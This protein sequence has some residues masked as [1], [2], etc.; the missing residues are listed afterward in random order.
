M[1]RIVHVRHFR[2][3]GLAVRAGAVGGPDV[4]AG[5]DVEG[6]EA[7]ADAELTTGNTGH[8]HVLD[9][10]RGNGDRGAILVILRLDL[11]RRAL[12]VTRLPQFLARLGIERDQ[13]AL[14]RVDVDL[15]AL[16][17][18]HA[19]VHEVAARDRD[20]VRRLLR[21]VLPDQRRAFLGQVER[22]H[23]V[24]ERRV[25]VHHVANDEGGSLVATQRARRERPGRLQARDVRRVDLRERAEA[26]EAVVPAGHLPVTIRSV[27]RPRP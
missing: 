9:H 12:R 25:H 18:R 15:A 20:R 13:V 5:V 21:D 1:G 7:A 11:R 6:R 27:A 17:V 10:D 3:E 16:V 23:D 24:R 14:Q 19:A 2:D 26:L 8:D 22:V 4:L